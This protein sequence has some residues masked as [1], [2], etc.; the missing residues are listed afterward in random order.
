MRPVNGHVHATRFGSFFLL[1]ITITWGLQ[2]RMQPTHTYVANSCFLCS[3]DDD[4]ASKALL[5]DEKTGC[6]MIE[7]QT[8]T[9]RRLLNCF[10][11]FSLPYSSSEVVKFQARQLPVLYQPH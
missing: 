2:G 5:Q 7:R 11:D 9:N 10:R 3:G 6:E 4:N 1:I 8:I